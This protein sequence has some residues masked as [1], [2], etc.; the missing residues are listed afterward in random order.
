MKPKYL[1]NLA[2]AS[3]AIIVLGF[4]TSKTQ[5]VDFGQHQFYSKILIN[6]QKND[7]S[8]DREVL[9][10]RYELLVSYDSLV[11]HIKTAQRMQSNL[12]N[13]PEF[14]DSKGRQELEG[15]VKANAE[16][17]EQKETALEKF[18]SQ[19]AIL[20]NSLRYFPVL[21]V[22]IADNFASPSGD[23]LLEATLHD[24][25][26]DI[27]LYNQTADEQIAPRIEAEISNL[28]E[29]KSK[30]KDTK[31]ESQIELAI[32]HARIIIKNKTQVDSL[33]QQML[34]LP[35][36][37]TGQELYQTYQRYY[38]RAIETA[39]G[40]RFYTYCW[41]L[42]FLCWI[43]YLLVSYFAKA[44][45][46]ALEAL[47]AKSRFL[48]TMS[49]EIRTPMNGV[50][51][52]VDVLAKTELSREQQDF[53]E[54][55]QISAENL[56]AIINDI[57][58]FSK[59][60][61]GEM[62]LETVEFDLR[63]NLENTV[64]L[65]AAQAYG[66]GLEIITWCDRE[67][68]D[69]LQGDRGRLRQI[70]LN[71]IGNAIKFTPKGEVIVRASLEQPEEFSGTDNTRFALAQPVRSTDAQHPRIQASQIQ[72]N[73]AQAN[74][75][76]AQANPAQANPAQAQA[77]HAQ[78]NPAFSPEAPIK[79]RFSVIDTGIGISASDQ[80]KL[81]QPFVQVDASSNRQYGGTGLGLAICKQLVELMD[82]EIGVEG[83]L[84]FGSTF[85]FTATFSGK[86]LAETTLTQEQ[87]TAAI[88]ARAA[89]A[90]NQ[91]SNN[92]GS[93]SYPKIEANNNSYDRNS[94]DE[95]H[96]NGTSLAN[97]EKNWPL[98]IEDLPIDLSSGQYETPR[99]KSDEEYQNGKGA[100][101]EQN[102]LPLQPGELPGIA[103]QREYAAALGESAFEDNL[104]LKPQTNQNSRFNSTGKSIL[105]AE[106]NAT[107]RQAI[108]YL[109]SAWEMDV[110]EAADWQQVLS[111]Q[112]E[113][114]LV[115]ANWNLV[116]DEDKLASK[117]IGH[118]LI[119]IIPFDRRHLAE[120]ILA[121][122]AAGYLTKPIKESR[123]QDILRQ[124]AT[125]EVA[126]Y[127]RDKSYKRNEAKSN[128]A[129]D[130]EAKDNEAKSNE[131]KQGDEGKANPQPPA[132]SSQKGSLRILVVDDNAINQKVLCQQ[133]K[134][135]GHETG[136]A[137][138]G[139]EALDILSRQQYDI[140]FM[141]CQMPV[142]DGYE[143]TRALRKQ[144]KQRMLVIALTAH[145]MKG[146]REK[147]LAAGMD[148]Y[149][150]KPVNMDVL[151]ATIERW[152]G[153]RDW[154]PGSE[155]LGEP[156]EKLQSEEKI[157]PKV[158]AS[159]SA[160]GEEQTKGDA[161]RSQPTTELQPTSLLINRNRLNEITDG[162]EEFAQE[163][164]D[165]Y[166]EDAENNLV[167]LRLAL[168]A[169]NSVEAAN[170]A[171]A[172]KGASGNVGVMPMQETAA[173]LERQA[174]A[175]NLDGA[176]ELVA[177][178]TATLDQVREFLANEL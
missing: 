50:L 13:I 92:Q 119:A 124:A 170:R 53:V 165:A 2:I 46:A 58:D 81:F 148:D 29:I 30:Y 147:C 140:A 11:R 176:G 67:I 61:A 127:T 154:A 32:A 128:E 43:S 95:E 106:E 143:A 99:A 47:E 142:L 145:A 174:R 14:I 149:L 110:D 93:T 42:I 108:A 54:T 56:L 68:P 22:E 72:A 102:T 113:Y 12:E 107:I 167:E 141:D 129:K 139:R 71:L 38:G 162:D 173:R 97:R 178:L 28:V 157:E 16:L 64:D 136:R 21:S 144:E 90:N 83:K 78:A 36:K 153:K 151:E 35:T 120:E 96:Y 121:L 26:H 31:V 155:P 70:L 158:I 79:I 156:E 94:D 118:R 177:T 87:L 89:L 161:P 41:S 134:R 137:N 77:N 4:L 86:I 117:A 33:L 152:F 159:F 39:S 112:K 126:S 160:I 88:P 69:T 131:A 10:D 20:K 82:G 172:I 49:H 37:E 150:S 65:L 52:M 27:L 85:W 40:Y 9:K 123:L 125:G 18:K 66:K 55:L 166:L 51:G 75:A 24:L 17:L 1:V 115:F 25:L 63:A 76:Q 59:L 19:A 175:E 169:N 15:I 60:E 114:D 135:L 104:Q 34:S 5:T 122:G 84:G 109:A 103:Y 45:E 138:N 146:D 57:L 98:A 91:G 168:E 116:M 133:L 100:A 171:H 132:A 3:G 164:L 44:R 74:P 80:K 130:N 23:F 62:H 6:Y 101:N 7:A 105:V 48:A 8:L 73:P 163:L 111:K